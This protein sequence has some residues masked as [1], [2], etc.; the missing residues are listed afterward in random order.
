M[1]RVMIYERPGPLTMWWRGPGR[2]LIALLA[3]MMSGFLTAYLV[4]GWPR[5][6]GFGRS[7]PGAS[8]ESTS[9]PPAEARGSP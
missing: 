9:P 3:L 2:P 8:A 6:P 4:F 1:T 5:V 7:A